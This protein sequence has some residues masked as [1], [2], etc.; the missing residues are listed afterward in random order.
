MRNLQ[1]PV[2]HTEPGR[3]FPGNQPVGD[4]GGVTLFVT[5]GYHLECFVLASLILPRKA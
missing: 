1:L 4:G 3:I 2:K 5:A